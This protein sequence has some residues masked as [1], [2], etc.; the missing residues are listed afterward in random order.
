VRIKP[1]PESA[2]VRCIGSPEAGLVADVVEED[3]GPQGAQL[4]DTGGE[5]MRGRA[6]L[7]REQLACRE[8]QAQLNARHLRKVAGR[9]RQTVQA[10]SERNPQIQAQPNKARS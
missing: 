7:R 10:A 8:A 3:G 1:Y 9:L 6:H 2:C 4:G 5:A